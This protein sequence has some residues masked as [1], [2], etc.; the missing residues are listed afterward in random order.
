[1]R[2]LCAFGLVL[3]VAALLASPALAQPP[4]GRGMGGMGGG[5]LG[6][7]LQNKSVQEELKLDKDQID[8][9]TEALK[10]F[11]EEHK[12]EYDKASFRNQDTKP[13]E[14]AEI[15]KKLAEGTTKLVG[16]ILKPEQLK[17]GHQIQKQLMGVA[18]FADAEAQ[19]TLKLTDEQKD[20]LKKLA[21]DAGKDI[22]EV[23]QSGGQGAFA[24]PEKRAELMKKT[25][26]ITTEAMEKA[27]K[28][29]KDDQKAALKEALGEKF[30]YKPD[31][32]R[33]PQQRN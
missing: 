33:R 19:K 7:L 9:I 25:A 2:K 12:D 29:L 8:K 30:D 28:M 5:G 31:P 11:R 20:D 32:P 13:E 26:A 3:G 6:Q 16:E 27:T 17:R 24:D 18:V 23:F 14:K 1:M 21:D 10:K 4:G 22:R 15:N